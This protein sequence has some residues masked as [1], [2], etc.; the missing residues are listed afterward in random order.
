MEPIQRSIDVAA[1]CEEVFS[2]LSHLER[3]GE[4]SPENT[5]GKW[6][7]G[8][9]GPSAGA[10]F[11]GTNARGDQRW[12]TLATVKTYLP[13]TSFVFRVTAGPFSVAEWSFHLEA[14]HEG[15]R[16]T[17]SSRDLRGR[18]VKLFE[19]GGDDRSLFTATSIEQTLAKLKAA[20]EAH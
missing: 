13:P 20:A 14:T 5:G 10:K 17:E 2:L 1:T 7:G 9:S 16:V 6:I 18:F 8:A 12:T 4:F 19:K 3:M 15:C 11:K